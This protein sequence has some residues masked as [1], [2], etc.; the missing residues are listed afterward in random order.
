MRNYLPPLT[1]MALSVA[2][3]MPAYAA[4]EGGSSLDR[5]LALTAKK[6]EA[7]GV[8]EIRAE[9]LKELGRNL[10][11]RAGLT[12]GS[13]QMLKEI[14]AK[15][16]FL[17]AKFNFNELTFPNGAL[18]PVIEEAKDVIS[19]MDY[20]MRVANKIYK[21]SAPARFRG[22]DWRNY[23]YLGLAVSK[24]PI[25]NESQRSIYPRDAAEQKY[26]DKVVREGY[27]DGLKEAVKVVEV[28]MNRLERDYIG[29]MMFYDLYEKK[30]VTPPV[31]ASATRGA[32][33]PDANT[34]VIGETIFRI[35]AQP[36]FN[37]NHNEWKARERKVPK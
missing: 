20:S 26:W 28:N 34:I 13:L 22:E 37:A 11:L 35:T 14:D 2:V 5:V 10:G 19:V 3:A 30:Q 25:V 31:F 6:E 18:P 24:D 7:I 8:P 21:I 27:A 12:D 23:L 16:E 1:V 15:T 29:M 9:A 32:H 33:K 17:N 36:T 4:N